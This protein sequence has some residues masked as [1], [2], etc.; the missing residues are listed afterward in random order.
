MSRAFHWGK[1]RQQNGIVE[2]GTNLTDT[3]ADINGM[4]AIDDNAG[5]LITGFVRT[6]ANR[7]IEG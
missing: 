3:A 6:G 4:F 1:A 7:I 5:I 2:G